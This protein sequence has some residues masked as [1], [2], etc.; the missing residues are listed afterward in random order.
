[1]LLTEDEAKTKWCPFAN[2]SGIANVP[3]LPQYEARGNRIGFPWT[4]APDFV[5]AQ[6]RCIASGCM[7]WRWVD[8]VVRHKK[9]GALH[10]EA[11]MKY[12]GAEETYERLPE[13]G[14]CGMAGRPEC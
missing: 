5:M 3:G 14:F 6:V 2:C 9:T 11:V 8:S 10:N 13:R 1:M 7:A 12:P 4:D